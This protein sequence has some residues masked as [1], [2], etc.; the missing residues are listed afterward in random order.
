MSAPPRHAPRAAPRPALPRADIVSASDLVRHFGQWQERAART[1]VYI[2]FRGRPRLV[3]TSI[4]VMEALL[5]PHLPDRAMPLPDAGA[6]LDLI[7]DM[8]IVADAHLRVI[9]ASKTARAFFGGSVAPGGTVDALV[10][11]P[12]QGA[13]RRALAQVQANGV[14]QALDLP[15]PRSAD[16]SLQVTIEPHHRGV[17]LRIEDASC[18]KSD[19]LS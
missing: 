10:P 5:A 2:L 1:P 14:A 7:R 17:A 13:L 12:A 16:R 9:A 19:E 6:L 4:E 3:L 11:A 18:R 8:V 15:S